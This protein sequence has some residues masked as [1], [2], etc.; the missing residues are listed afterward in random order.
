MLEPFT[1]VGAYIPDHPLE[2]PSP[3]YTHAGAITD[4]VL[5]SLIHLRDCSLKGSKLVT[6]RSPKGSLDYVS[7]LVV[8]RRV[9][10]LLQ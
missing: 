1:D 3:Y 6:A 2:G 8:G 7:W 4:V 5:T 9:L 10:S